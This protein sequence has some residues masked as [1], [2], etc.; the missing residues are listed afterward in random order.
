MDRNRRLSLALLYPGDRAARD[1]S[2]PAES[3]FAALFDAFAAAGVATEPAIYH[4]DFADEV[5]AQLRGVDGVLVWSNPIESG[6]RRERLDA[7]LRELAQGGVFV[8]THP[9]T[10]LRLGT[11]DVLLDTRDLPFGSD[12]VRVDNLE[13]LTSE[14]PQ[15]LQRGPRVL[16]QH[17][18][19]SGIGVWR[20]EQRHGSPLLSV[21]HAQRGCEEEQIDLATL[22]HRL[23]S[24]FE[25]QNGG[26]MIDQAWQPGLV[27]GMVRAYLVEDRVAGFGHQA[28][29]ALYP[30]EPGEAAPLPGPRL[31]H[32]ADWP[33]AQRLKGLLESGWVELLCQCVSLQRDQLPLLWDCDFLPGEP[34][35]DR[36][37]RYV[38]CEINVSSVSPF[39][40]SVVQPLVTATRA[41]LESKRI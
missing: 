3:R 22:R 34:G 21:R 7:M 25:P 30:G 13:H 1:R 29:N 14:L 20:V 5:A 10:I 9:D 39:P 12:T 32:P 16:K 33:P 27:S 23:A 26:H 41:R 28:V 31:Y 38:L 8:S 15:R 4:D 17:R 37:E 11:K 6:H 36:A 24:Y 35:A 40:P 2:D 19:H 18:G